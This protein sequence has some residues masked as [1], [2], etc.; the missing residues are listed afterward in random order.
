MQG[1]ST[2]GRHRC[3]RREVIIAD[4]LLRMLPAGHVATQDRQDGTPN[5]INSMSSGHLPASTDADSGPRPDTTE[6]EMGDFD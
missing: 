2:R 1:L 5:T 4:L 3:N 6:Q